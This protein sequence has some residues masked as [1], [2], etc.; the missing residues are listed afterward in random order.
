MSNKD[1][2]LK[3]LGDLLA[4]GQVSADEVLQVVETKSANPLDVGVLKSLDNE[5]SDILAPSRVAK[6]QT[7]KALDSTD[8][9]ITSPHKFT[10]AMF[11]AAGV[12][13][14]AALQAG[15][16]ITFAGEWLVNLLVNFIFGAVCWAVV[17]VARREAQ[18]SNMAQG[19]ALAMFSVGSL[20]MLAAPTCAGLLAQSVSGVG[21]GYADLVV[22]FG[23]LALVLLF[24]G[25]YAAIKYKPAL[26]VGAF[27]LWL[28]FCALVFVILY[29]SGV[30]ETLPYQWALIMIG[31]L[32]PL[33][34]R[35][36]D[37]K[38]R[39]GIERGGFNFFGVLIVLGSMYTYTWGEH[40]LE[41]Y[42]ALGLVIFGI[43]C[44]AVVARLRALFL[45]ASVATVVVILTFCY[46]YI[47]GDSVVLGL[48]IS[49]LAVL[50]CALGLNGLHKKYFSGR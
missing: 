20:A 48:F 11:V 31:L 44:W 18:H 23:Y 38:T 13:M 47:G 43:F 46:K 26:G 42:S 19:L 28:G 21:N 25:Y 33:S 27:S 2:V 39:Y 12:I 49:A 17:Y 50:M 36:M 7:A 32:L 8:V 4:A 6:L 15:L 29:R 35:M 30:S 45:L 22:A 41:W 1:K 37:F 24:A 16:D 14:F 34:A 3:S 40:S 5:A 9:K 10:D